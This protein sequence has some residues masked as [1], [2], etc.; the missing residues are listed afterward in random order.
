MGRVVVSWACRIGK[1]QTSR[2]AREGIEGVDDGD[3]DVMQE[4]RLHD[5]LSY[6]ET[7]TGR[8]ALLLLLALGG[9]RLPAGALAA[10]GL[11][12]S[13]CHFDDVCFSVLIV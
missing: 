12:L 1:R 3:D 5:F 6:L 8:V 13:T 9:R 2:V 4:C 10:R 7:S 11:A